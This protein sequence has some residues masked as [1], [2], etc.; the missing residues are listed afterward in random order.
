MGHSLPTKQSNELPVGRV[1]E[2]LVSVLLLFYDSQPATSIIQYQISV[3]GIIL[4]ATSH[5]L[6]ER[7]FPYCKVISLFFFS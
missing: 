1:A 5:L 4:I 6:A 2:S 7:E 3:Y